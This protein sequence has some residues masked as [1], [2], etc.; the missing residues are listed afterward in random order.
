MRQYGM[1]WHGMAWHGMAWHDM[2]SSTQ[3]NTTKRL[4]TTSHTK[5]ID[6]PMRAMGAHDTIQPAC[7][8]YTLHAAGT[9]Y[10]LVH[11]LGDGTEANP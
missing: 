11:D 8:D 5:E 6:E 10:R 7:N 2:A 3:E 4:N 9:M 1:A